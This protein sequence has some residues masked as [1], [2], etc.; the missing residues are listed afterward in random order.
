MPRETSITKKMVIDA[1]FEIVRKNG[2]HTL[3]ARSIAKQL[4]CSTQPIYWIYENMDVLKQDVIEKII[5]YLTEKIHSFNKTGR[6]F[7]DFG[8]GY[9]QTAY[10]EPMLFK[11]IYFDNILNLKFTDITPEKEMIEIMRKD[12]CTAN[13]TDEEC[14]HIAVKSWVFAYGLASLHATGMMVYN[15]E[16]I[17]KMLND[18]I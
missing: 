9:I 7:L 16:K 1:A 14:Y 8:I 5:A 10:N 18:F 4:G 15:E 11:L 12:E 17:E 13:L 2:F 3:T 6:P